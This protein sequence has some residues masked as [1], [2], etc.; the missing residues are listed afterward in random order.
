MEIEKIERII[1]DSL[2]K[3]LDFDYDIF[4]GDSNENKNERNEI[5][6]ELH[7]ITINHRFAYYLESEL[8]K[9]ESYNCYSVDL[10]YNRYFNDRKKLEY[11]SYKDIV[12]PDI[13]IHTRT[14]HT[15]LPMHLLVIEA[16]K[17]KNTRWDE[18]KILGFI[19]DTNYHYMYGLTLSYC[20]SENEIIGKLFYKENN[21]IKINEISIDK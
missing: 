16:K 3:L 1:K 6:R 7:E 19:E 2:K 15:E 9:E 13:I 4:C 21:E 20:S 12:R 14:K 5:D 8:R 17:L 10:E 18:Q 11:D